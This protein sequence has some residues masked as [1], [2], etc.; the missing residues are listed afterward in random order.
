MSPATPTP[1]AARSQGRG[2]ASGRPSTSPL[3]W[4]EDRVFVWSGVSRRTCRP[5][6]ELD[7]CHHRRE[8]R[9]GRSFVIHNPTLAAI[10]TPDLEEE[11]PLYQ[12]RTQLRRR[13][14][15][16]ASHANADSDGASAPD[17]RIDA[18]R[19]LRSAVHEQGAQ[20]LAENLR[21][22][23]PHLESALPRSPIHRRS[24]RQQWVAAAKRLGAGLA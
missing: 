17:R 18:W 9:I 14:L 11:R 1:P 23:S 16:A 15:A 6:N 24:F 10:S 19:R 2:L 22:P 5:Q 8:L 7:A 12:L 4:D 3:M 13:R 21:G 20:Y